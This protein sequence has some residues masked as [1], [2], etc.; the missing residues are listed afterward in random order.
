L[1]EAIDEFGGS[2]VMVTHNEMHLRAVATKLVVF[3][4]DEIIVYPGSYDDFLEDV[5]WSDEDYN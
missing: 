1:I 4:K 3:D 2:I 5:G